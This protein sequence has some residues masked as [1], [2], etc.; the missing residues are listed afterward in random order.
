METPKVL[1]EIKAADEPL[2]KVVEPTVVQKLDTNP[3]PPT[4][5]P[6]SHQVS[7][8]P[9]TAPVIKI[10]KEDS[11]T[12]G[13]AVA[14]AP[15]AAVAPFV[16]VPNVMIDTEPSVHFTPY[17]TVFDETTQGISHIRY[18]PKDGDGNDDGYDAP[19][20]LSFGTTANAIV[21]EDAED[22]E[23]VR[24]PTPVIDDVDAPLGTTED[25]EVLA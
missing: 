11:A 18:S 4:I 7:D 10:S 23:P 14:V 24:G 5:V 3:E 16:P 2:P 17:D 21:A 1:A 13:G 25:F 19:P 9:V 6:S 12:V 15:V 20:R 22:L 8:V